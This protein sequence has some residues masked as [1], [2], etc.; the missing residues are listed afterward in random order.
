MIEIISFPTFFLTNYIMEILVKRIAKKPSYTIG[1]LY[2]NGKLFCNTLEDTDRGLDQSMSPDEIA[3]KKIKDKTAIPTGTYR[4]TLDVVSPRFSKKLGYR[5]CGGKLPRLLNT[6]GFSG[7]LIHSG[8]TAEH[9]SGCILVGDN[10]VKGKVLDSMD[11]L[12]KL[13]KV[14]Q[15]AK[16]KGEDI[17]ITIE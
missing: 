11:T 4:I 12:K 15:D 6:V 9:T 7:V 8:N 13:Y 3:R 14:M 16:K 1:K 17:Y 5:W 10:R 2:V